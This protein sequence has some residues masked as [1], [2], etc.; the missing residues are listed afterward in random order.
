MTDP[1]VGERLTRLEEVVAELDQFAAGVGQRVDA[2]VDRHTELAALV[3]NLA[4]RLE[5]LNEA[6]DARFAD[7]KQQLGDGSEL[8]HT[9][10][11]PLEQL[12]DRSADQGADFV[13]RVT[14]RLVELQERVTDIERTVAGRLETG[15]GTAS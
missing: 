5:E 15:P 3:A 7:R 4:A 14:V 9:A 8:L 2:A 11:T 1:T 10:A 13:D 12:G 6:V